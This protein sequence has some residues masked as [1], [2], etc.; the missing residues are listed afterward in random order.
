MLQVYDKVLTSYNLS[1]LTVITVGAVI[2]LV[3]MALLEWIRSR[4]LVRA[5]IEFDNMLGEPVLHHNLSNA[6]QPAGQPQ[7]ESQ[8][9]L[10]DVQLLR[11]F[12]GGNAVF[13]FFDL[14]WM[15]I[16]LIFIFILH[17]SLGWVA[18]L[19]GILVFILGLTT[20]RLTRKRLEAA[21]QLNVHAANFTGAAMRNASIVRSM[22]MV[23]NITSRWRKMNNIIINLQTQ[24]SKNAGLIH[25]ISKALRVGLQVA[26][27][28]VGAY[29]TVMHEST[30][31]VMIA[32]SIIMGRSLAP[33]DQAMATYKQSLEAK[34]AYKRLDKLLTMQPTSQPMELPAPKGN[35]TAENLYF[36]VGNRQLIKNISFHLPA[37][38]SLAIIGPSAAGKSTLCKL[39]LN[40]WTP[41]AGK[42][43]IDGA[44]I[45]SWDAERLGPYIGYL[46]QDVE[47]FSGTVAE[48]IARLGEVDS[49]KVIRA[50]QIAGVHPMILA[51]PKGYD[52]PIGELG[53]A[54]SGGQRQRIGLARALYGDPK[55]IVLD[56]PNS[57]LD[58]AGDAC[59]IQA[60][61]NLKQL[62]STVVLVTHKPNILS[63]VD[64]I[65]LM[66]DGQIALS[67]S[68]DDVLNKLEA[69]RQE[70]VRQAELARAQ[71]ESLNPSKSEVNSGEAQEADNE[72]QQ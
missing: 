4:L 67:G 10:R 34:T 37:G 50:A 53:T 7:Q 33:I 61:L 46:P 16:Y 1:T 72:D 66:Q 36:V 62:G 52:T 32:A 28:A 6:T 63:I 20:E 38:A 49:Q 59:L 35:L 11:N 57:N 17:P 47:L 51:L 25:S 58:E 54:L 19:G 27:Y 23:G 70:Q 65:I 71:Q 48:N 22:G 3:V 56:E 45:M 29:L 5:G 26:I 8:G 68:R 13:A 69:L 12:L 9:T 15:P 40:I 60:I 30:A 14:P 43:R 24:A 2:C 42:T 31:G 18:V 44:D 41:S 39:L 64:N 55:L 21:T